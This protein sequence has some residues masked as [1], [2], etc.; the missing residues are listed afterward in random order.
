[1]YWFKSCPRCGGDL[2]EGRDHYAAYISC[3][4]CGHYLTPEQEEALRVGTG[5]GLEVVAGAKAEREL[6]AVAI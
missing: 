4:Q 2:S 1:M 6:M 5:K 3:I